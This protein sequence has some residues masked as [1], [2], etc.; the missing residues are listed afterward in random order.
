MS[1]EI[2]KFDISIFVIIGIFAVVYY[3]LCIFIKNL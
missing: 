3:K 2:S 1:G